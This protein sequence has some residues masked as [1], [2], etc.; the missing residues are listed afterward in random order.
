[1]GFRTAFYSFLHGGTEVKPSNNTNNSCRDINSFNETVTADTVLNPVAFPDA[2]QA[3]SKPVTAQFSG[4][5]CEKQQ[6]KI[7]TPV[8]LGIPVKKWFGIPYIKTLSRPIL[9]QLRNLA[10]SNSIPV[11]QEIQLEDLKK[12]TLRMLPL[13]KL[14]DAWV[15]YDPTD[16]QL[17]INP[18]NEIVGFFGSPIPVN[19][20]VSNKIL[21]SKKLALE[22]EP[23]LKE[24]LQDSR[25]RVYLNTMLCVDE[26]YR[27]LG[28]AGRMEKATEEFI[29]EKVTRQDPAARIDLIITHDADN[30]ASARVHDKLG[31]QRLG[32]YV[33]P[34]YSNI[35]LSIRAKVLNA[36]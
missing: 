36:E 23:S 12:G 3:M 25:T 11:S 4:Q 21:N 27:G 19:R 30:V 34:K 20:M 2:K 7:G 29:L 24:A 13:Q 5:E 32:T 26:K 33:N 31:Y 16:L 22:I 10:G 15:I 14:W 1:M 8:D 18:E 28:L 6:I 9:E 17:A 35:K